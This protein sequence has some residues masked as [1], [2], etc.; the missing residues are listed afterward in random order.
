MRKL[1]Y[2][3]K[4]S[5]QVH[6]IKWCKSY[7]IESNKSQRHQ[8]GEKKTFLFKTGANYRHFCIKNR[9][10]IHVQGDAFLF[11]KMSWWRIQVWMVNHTSLTRTLGIAWKGRIK[12]IM[13][14][15]IIL[16]VDFEKWRLV[17]NDVRRKEG[18]NNERRGR[19]WKG[20]ERRSKTWQIRTRE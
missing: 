6:K 16:K 14:F 3:F 7:E 8:C 17:G 10:I 15:L 4:L 18:N 12:Q 13:K 2:N 20:R 1:L 5:N 19:E 11:R 9:G